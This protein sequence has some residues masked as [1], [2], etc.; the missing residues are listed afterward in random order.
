MTSAAR[1]AVLAIVGWTNSGKTTLLER[2]VAHFTAAGL[3]VSTI[4]HAHHDLD[5]DQPGRDTWR[6]RQAGA[7][8][9]IL[10]TSARTVVFHEHRNEPP[11]TL[12]GLLARLEPCDLVLV[13]GF[14]HA[15]GPKLEVRRRA[16]GKPPIADADPD[17]IAVASDQ[18]IGGL[19]V[20]TFD[21]DDIGSIARFVAK[22]ILGVGPA[23]FKS[24][25]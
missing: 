7:R 25:V 8:E 23:P 9:V 11:P 3:T 2:L 24:N 22:R 6:H 5:V 18:P 21:L 1:P 20:P 13:E 19:Q 10:A 15:P 17:V 14:K 16:G 12:D 4:K